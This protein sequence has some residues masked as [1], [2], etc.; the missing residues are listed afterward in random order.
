MMKLDYFKDKLFEL[1]ND[2]DNMRIKNITTNDKE[3]KFTV[4][5]LDGSIFEVKCRKLKLSERVGKTIKR[6]VRVCWKLDNH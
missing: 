1:L 3:D 2:A 4:E 5:I 6:N